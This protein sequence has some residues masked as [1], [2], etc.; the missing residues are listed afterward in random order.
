MKITLDSQILSKGIHHLQNITS[1][2]STLPVLSNLLIETGESQIQ[3]TGTDLE[4]GITTT[5]PAQIH[6]PGST[7]I[8][9]RRFGDLIKEL[10]AQPVTITVKKNHIAVLECEKSHFKLMGLPPEEF[11]KL[12]NIPQQQPIQIPQKALSSMLDMTVFAMSHDESRYVLNGIYFAY[13]KGK[14]RLV[15]TD[16]RRL[17]MVERAMNHSGGDQRAIIPTKA[18]HELHR[19]LGS[20]E[21]VKIIFGG[22]QV[23]FELGASTLVSRTVEGEFP[24]YEQVI[25]PEVHEKVKLSREAFLLAIRRASLWATPESQ[26][27]KLDLGKNKLVISKQTP[28]LGEAREEVEA[29]YAGQEMS[30]GFNPGYLMDVLKSLPEE[31]I[32]VELPGPER[33]GVIRTKD[34]YVY[35]VLPMQLT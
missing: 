9:A 23:K 29:E 22:N 25:P 20:D 15:A 34:Q 10:P 5:I 1:S 14:L 11:P 18:I 28:D 30:V 24:N 16:G 3:L 31:L 26:S 7:T 32:D 17:A 2:R 19:L 13:K 4:I 35:I 21:T 8:P 12:P 6:E 33:P 27:V